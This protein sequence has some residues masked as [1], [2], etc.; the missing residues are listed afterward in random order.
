MIFR[1]ALGC[2]KAF[3]QPTILFSHNKPATSN[4][5]SVL[6]SQNESAP[7][8]SQTN[9][10]GTTDSPSATKSTPSEATPTSNSI[11]SFPSTNMNCT[12]L[13]SYLG[14]HS[15]FAI[16]YVKWAERLDVCIKCCN[17][18]TRPRVS[19]DVQIFDPLLYVCDSP[20][21]TRQKRQGNL[22]VIA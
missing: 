13:H 9:R 7:A 3:H 4:Q 10:L 6:F 8:T 14:F 18:R 19:F 15:I 16:L 5:P 21:L 17:L 20:D 1:E 11:S 22:L 12:W 2:S